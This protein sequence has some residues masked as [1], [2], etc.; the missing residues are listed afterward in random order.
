MGLTKRFYKKKTH[1]LCVIQ[2][3]YSCQTRLLPSSD[4]RSAALAALER[5]FSLVNSL[6]F[7]MQNSRLKFR[8]HADGYV[9]AD[10]P[11]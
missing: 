4:R 3:K 9:S 1:A 10:T 8:E 5:E 2:V 7:R 6:P 11:V